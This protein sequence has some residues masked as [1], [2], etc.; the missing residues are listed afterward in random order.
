MVSSLGEDFL[1]EF[2]ALT[3]SLNGIAV[4]NR[5]PFQQA[6]QDSGTGT[7]ESARTNNNTNVTQ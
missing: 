5:A 3:T 4:K 1:R 2:A 7:W 6:M